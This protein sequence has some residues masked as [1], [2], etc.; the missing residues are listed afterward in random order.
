MTASEWE[1]QPPQQDV[2]S[3][4]AALLGRNVTYLRKSQRLNKQ[5]FSLMIGVSRPYLNGI[6]SGRVDARLSIVERIADALSV[7]IGDL[8]QVELSE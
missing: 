3:K 2:T 6:E 5:T 4:T 1:N 8:L 7:E